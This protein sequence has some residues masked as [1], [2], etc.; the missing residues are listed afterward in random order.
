MSGFF[1]WLIDLQRRQ[2]YFASGFLF[3]HRFLKIFMRLK[4][5]FFF[6]FHMTEDCVGRMRE[7]QTSDK[8]LEKKGAV[9]KSGNS[10]SNA[11]PGKDFRSLPESLQSL[12]SN[13]DI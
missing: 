4:L 2:L 12:T 1:L 13:D 6:L 10:E 3:F 5:N 7:R 8:P 11:K 9:W